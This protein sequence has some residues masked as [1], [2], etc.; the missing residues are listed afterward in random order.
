MIERVFH[1][2][3]ND[4]LKRELISNEKH[5][6]KKMDEFITHCHQRYFGEHFGITPQQILNGEKPNKNKFTAQIQIAQLQRRVTNK[7][8]NGCT[9]P[10]C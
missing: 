4:F 2:F 9:M 6:I 7:N 3:K 8:F 10:S 5:L 1:L